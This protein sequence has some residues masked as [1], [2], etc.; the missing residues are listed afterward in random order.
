MERRAVS[1]FAFLEMQS[2]N[3]STTTNKN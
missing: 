1:L 2:N 3:T